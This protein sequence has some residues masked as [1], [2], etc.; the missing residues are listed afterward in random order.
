M[1]DTRF[2]AV[3]VGSWLFVHGGISPKLALKHS[4]DH[5]NY[6]TKQWLRGNRSRNILNAID[7]I[8]HNDDNDYSPYWSRVYSD[9]DDWNENRVKYLFNSTLKIL[10]SKNKGNPIKGMILGHSPQYMWD[11]GI[12]ASF[13]NRLWRVDV[14]MSRA[15]G[16]LNKNRK[17]R[18]I[19]VLE[20]TNDN[21]YS[22][23][24]EA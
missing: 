24:T 9:Y 2:C 14:G 20:I 8:F 6:Y 18:K 7:D 12:N 22:I 17:Y 16:P 23:L 1:A 4:L 21:Q 19:Q 3:Q 10:N 11:R 5:L 15:F 13:N